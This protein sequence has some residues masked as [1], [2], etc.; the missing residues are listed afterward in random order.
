MFIHHFSFSLFSFLG[1]T[2]YVPP[3]WFVHTT[4]LTPSVA[5]VTT[6]DS[7]QNAHSVGDATVLVKFVCV[8]FCAAP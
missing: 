6:Y 5:A 3:Y 8:L 4:T 7:W 1:D 2:V